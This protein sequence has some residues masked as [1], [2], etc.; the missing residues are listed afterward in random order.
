MNDKSNMAVLFLC[1]VFCSG[2]KLPAATHSTGRVHLSCRNCSHESYLLQRGNETK[3]PAHESTCAIHHMWK[4]S[5]SAGNFAS[6]RMESGGSDCHKW[7]RGFL[8]LD[9]YLRPNCI[10]GLSRL[11]TQGMTMFFAGILPTNGAVLLQSETASGVLRV[12]SRLLFD[13]AISNAVTWLGLP[14]EG[15]YPGG[16]TQWN[17]KLSIS[18]FNHRSEILLFPHNSTLL[19][20]PPFIH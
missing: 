19:I 5:G 12:A 1:A 9:R 2:T 16:A 15:L 17:R 8:F 11:S 7:G 14:L 20:L 6:R 4:S 10:S 3:S 18:L 13:A